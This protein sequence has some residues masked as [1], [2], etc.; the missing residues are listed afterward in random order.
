MKKLVLL[1]TIG[2]FAGCSSMPQ[3]EKMTDGRSPSSVKSVTVSN[4]KELLENIK[5]DTE[6]T[7]RPGTY[8]VT[9]GVTDNTIK[10]PNIETSA[11]FDGT[12]VHIKG[13]KNLVLKSDGKGLPRIVADPT[14][15]KVL[16]FRESENITISALMIG[17]DNPGYCEGAVLKFV[18]T[19]NV[20]INDRT[21]LYGSGTYAVEAIGS[22]VKIDNSILR[23]GSYGI[24]VASSSTLEISKSFIKGN[25]E[26]DLF[27]VLDN[28]RVTV[29]N[30]TITKNSGQTMAE[31]SRDSKLAFNNSTFSSNA[32]AAAFV[33]S[34]NTTSQ[35][36]EKGE[37]TVNGKVLSESEALRMINQKRARPKRK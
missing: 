14:Y 19:N 16:T 22:Q 28:S 36:V 11:A 26:F 25:A 21:E 32:M 6:I 9:A 24:I 12:E 34:Y 15:A 35:V 1:A 30:S 29:S 10:N 13:V 4:V 37:V 18:G 17:H 3:A 23:D 20:L 7:L 8:N 31:V 27:S 2:L 5:S 33:G